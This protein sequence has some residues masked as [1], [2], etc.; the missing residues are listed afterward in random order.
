MATR[1][2]RCDL[3]STPDRQAVEAFGVGLQPAARDPVLLID[4]LRLVATRAGLGHGRDAHPGGRIARRGDGMFPVTVGTDRRLGHPI[5]HGDAVDAPDIGSSLLFVALATGLGNVFPV[6]GRLGV[7]RAAEVMTF[8][9][10]IA[11]GGRFTGRHGPTVNTFL[12]ELVRLGNRDMPSLH[13]GAVGVTV[14]ARFRRAGAKG[15]RLRICVTADAVGLAVAIEAQ[16]G[17]LD[18]T[19]QRPGMDAPHVCPD[20][21]AVAVPAGLCPQ[22]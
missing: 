11:G 22:F 17:I 7:I 1:A 21:R 5:D 4:A 6:D 20:H 8:M 18:P 2:V 10:V 12:I 13:Q 9:A 3:G 15:G 19:G 16:G 14:A